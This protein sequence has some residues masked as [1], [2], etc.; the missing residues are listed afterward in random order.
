MKRARNTDDKRLHVL[1]NGER[2][3]WLEQHAHG[4][5]RF[6]YDGEWVN[7]GRHALSLSMPTARELHDKRVTEAFFWNLLPDN[8]TALDEIAKRQER[9]GPCS[10]QSL[11][12][13]IAKAGM[14][15]PGALQVVREEDLDEAVN[16]GEIVPISEAQIAQRLRD[17]QRHPALVRDVN[18]QGQFSLAGA[19]PKTAYSKTE[20]GWAE[21]SGRHATTHIFKP[22]NPGFDGLIE[23][24]HVCLET[25]R[26]LGMITARSEILHFEDMAAIVVERYDRRDGIRIHQEDF[27]QANA[28][29]PGQKYETDGGPGI[30]AILR[31]LDASNRPQED[32]ARFWDA[33][34]LNWMLLGTDAHAKNYSLLI[35]DSGLRLAPLYDIA[36]FY[37]FAGNDPQKLA[38]K[39][40]GQK[41][42]RDI[43]PRH[44]QAIA[45]TTGENADR[46]IERIRETARNLPDAL[47]AAIKESISKDVDHK[48]YNSLL[49]AVADTCRWAQKNYDQ[50]PNSSAAELAAI[51]IDLTI[52]PMLI[53]FNEEREYRTAL[54]A[55]KTIEEIFAILSSRIKEASRKAKIE[56]N[57]LHY[58]IKIGDASVVITSRD[59]RSIPLN[60]FKQTIYAPLSIV[61]SNRRTKRSA[62]LCYGKIH[63]PTYHWFEL[64]V[65]D[66]YEFGQMPTGQ[67]TFGVIDQ[68]LMGRGGNI[69]L[70]HSPR[71]ID[72]DGISAFCDRWIGYLVAAAKDELK[73]PQLPEPQ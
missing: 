36:S 61:V 14:D 56:K 66:E 72:G 5:V 1:I 35:A 42:Q 4:D 21:P 19:Q 9:G 71:I 73:P 18:R 26:R 48:H 70:A 23:I 10:P 41:Y 40:G 2:I 50:R 68:V 53:A 44:W 15:C 8:P 25:A 45:E 69:K 58:S 32:R 31:N 38:M 43:L 46:L 51:D 22:V 49:K 60:L 47:G 62:L 16:G 34:I 3:G 28:V 55:V 30:A 37:P 67:V 17:L 20:N 27:C 54:K 6:R 65:Y 29:R 63:T 57:G 13:M 39:I 59:V 33:I 24:E 64:S 52:N 12:R 7:A 11:F